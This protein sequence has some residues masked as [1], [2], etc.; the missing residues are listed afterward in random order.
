MQGK[1]PTRRRPMPAGC[2]A[3][4]P[5]SAGRAMRRAPSRGAWPACGRSTATSGARGGHRRPGGRTAQPEAAATAAAAAAG[6]GRD[7]AARRDPDR[8]PAGR[9][10]PGDVRDALR[11]RAAGRRARR[12]DLDDLDLEQELVR[13]RGKGRRERLC[14]SA[15]WPRPGSAAGSALRQPEAARRAGALPQPVRRP[16]SRPGA[17]AGCSR[18]TSPA[19]ASTAAPSP[20][21]LRHSFATHLLDRGADLRSVQEL[22][23][24]RSL[25]TTQIYTHVTQ[26]RLLD[27]YQN[28]HPAPEPRTILAGFALADCISCSQLTRSATARFRYRVRIRERS[29]ARRRAV[30]GLTCH[31]RICGPSISR[32]ANRRF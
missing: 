6:R 31:G 5:G 9:A 30:R 25:T 22:L 26:E 10:R 18:S 23:G 1:V 13:V 28:A 32:T 4:R 7:P 24:H 20:H 17:S 14:P 29:R 11:R 2:G 27:A 21:T 12:P 3:T 15:R 8:R 16:G 19:S